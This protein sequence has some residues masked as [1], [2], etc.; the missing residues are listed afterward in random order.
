MKIETCEICNASFVRDSNR[1]DKKKVC[2]DCLIK[3]NIKNEK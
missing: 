2:L 1:K 3:Q